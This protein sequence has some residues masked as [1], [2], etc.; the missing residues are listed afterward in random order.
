VAISA[1]EGEQNALRDGAGAFNETRARR[2]SEKFP[3]QQEGVKVRR[4][5]N[6]E[7]CRLSL[8]LGVGVEDRGG[9]EVKAKKK[10]VVHGICDYTG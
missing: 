9:E 10:E 5:N 2:A 1:V 6:R 8:H 4:K 7:L 3:H